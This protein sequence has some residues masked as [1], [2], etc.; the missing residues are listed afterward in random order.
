RL[1]AR[2]KN[3]REAVE[4]DPECVLAACRK[5]KL[6]G[7]GRGYAEF[8]RAPVL[9]DVQIPRQRTANRWIVP[10]C[11]L[12]QVAHGPAPSAYLS[13]DGAGVHLDSE[14]ACRLYLW[15]ARNKCGL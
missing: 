11:Q 13:S 5:I 3:W 8:G 10:N 12:G 2:E 9:R 1:P 15:S 7:D 14:S 4:F 6:C